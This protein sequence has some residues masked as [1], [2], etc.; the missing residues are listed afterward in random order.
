MELSGSRPRLDDFASL[1]CTT[2]CPMDIFLKRLGVKESRSARRASPN[3][4][5]SRGLT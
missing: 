4:R 3:V 2:F 1:A 5:A